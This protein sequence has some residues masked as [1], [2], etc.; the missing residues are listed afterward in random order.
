[1]GFWRYQQNSG[2]YLMILVYMCTSVCMCV[3][4]YMS[5]CLYAYLCIYTF[6]APSFMPGTLHCAWQI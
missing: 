6:S 1:M 2:I 4:I 3:Y 5:V